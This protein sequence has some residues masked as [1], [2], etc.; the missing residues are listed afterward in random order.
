SKRTQNNLTRPNTSWA[1]DMELSY[2]KGKVLPQ[3]STTQLTTS[4]MDK[5][6]K[7]FIET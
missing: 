4:S 5:N 2:K 7:N 1:K 6:M 3:P